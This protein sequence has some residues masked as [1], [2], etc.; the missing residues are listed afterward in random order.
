MLRRRRRTEAP[1]EA[2]VTLGA[3]ICGQERFKGK[4]TVIIDVYGIRHIIVNC[5]YICIYTC[6][7]FKLYVYRIQC[8]RNHLC[9]DLWSLFSALRMHQLHHPNVVGDSDRLSKDG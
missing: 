8:G 5:M 4:Y 3:A 9:R 2:E 1:L 6:I 7:Y